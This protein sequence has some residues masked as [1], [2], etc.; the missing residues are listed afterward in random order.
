MTIFLE[1]LSLGGSGLRVAVKDTIDI[2]GYPTRAASRALADMPP[3][4]R[5]AD[6]VQAVLN[7]GC[8]IVGKA[9][10]HELAFGVTGINY[11]TG[12]A[13]NPKYPGRI[14][15]GSSSG[16][17]AAVAAGLADFALG[18]DTGGSVR[19]PAACCGIYGLKPTFGRVSRKGVLPVESSLDCVGPFA[20]DVDLLIRAMGI[21]DQSFAG[22]RPPSLSVALIGVDADPEISSM[23]R[24][25]VDCAGLSVSEVVLLGM[26]AAFDAGLAIIGAETWT[27]FGYLV[28]TGLV[29]RDVVQRLSSG[30]DVRSHDLA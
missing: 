7:V 17:A 10:M 14:P 3:A 9:N 18:T 22:A 26:E 19:V 15:G 1:E 11:A 4:Q 28:A 29:G 24:Q 16:S 2:A 21:I 25:A 27:A 12:T 8:R 20:G 13:P 6:V 5:N 30:R 23:V